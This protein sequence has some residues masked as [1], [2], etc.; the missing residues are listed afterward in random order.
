MPE[1][2]G[3]GVLPAVDGGFAGRQWMPTAPRSLR[4]GRHGWQLLLTGRGSVYLSASLVSPG[5]QG[6]V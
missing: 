6:L 5:V 3:T 2:G 4:G 1:A